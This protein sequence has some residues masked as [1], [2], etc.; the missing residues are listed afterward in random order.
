[1][2]NTKSPSTV[3]VL[4]GPAKLPQPGAP[5]LPILA[6][7]SGL[8]SARFNGI[9]QPESAFWP[10]VKMRSPEV[11]MV[12]KLDPS[13]IAFHNN[14]GPPDGHNLSRL[15]SVERPSRFGPRHRS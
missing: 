5:V 2:A 13:P 12:A 1:M 4:R 11:T 9:T 7:Q 10:I 14:F 6:D 8:P 15:V 3:S